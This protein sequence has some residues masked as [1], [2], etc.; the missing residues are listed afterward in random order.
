MTTTSGRNSRNGIKC[1]KIVR[2]ETTKIA[3]GCFNKQYIEV[4]L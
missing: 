3:F 1:T 2:T 4:F